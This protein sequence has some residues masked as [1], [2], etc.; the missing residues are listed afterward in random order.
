MR[1]DELGGH[2][3]ERRNEYRGKWAPSPYPDV[4]THLSSRCG[5]KPRYARCRG[6]SVPGNRAAS[7]F[8]RPSARPAFPL[9]CPLARGLA[10]VRVRYAGSWLLTCAALADNPSS[11]TSTA[12]DN[13]DDPIEP[14]DLASMR[15]NGFRTDPRGPRVVRWGKLTGR[16]SPNTCQGKRGWANETSLALGR[17]AGRRDDTTTGSG[18]NSTLEG[19]RLNRGRWSQAEGIQRNRHPC[20][21]D[22]LI[23]RP[24][25]MLASPDHGWAVRV[26]DLEP[27]PCPTRLVRL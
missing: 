9:E 21:S 23:V 2:R 17:K 19:C 25:E 1:S 7:Y 15:A 16:P 5:A 20:N 22:Q 6:C 13:M 18:G 3:H 10:A 26:L 11:R 14:M 12:A 27:M 4:P 8:P 24:R